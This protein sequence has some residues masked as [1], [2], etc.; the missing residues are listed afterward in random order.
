[1]ALAL[2][3]IVFDVVLALAVLLEKAST[4]WEA[5]FIPPVNPSVL[6]RSLTAISDPAISLT[7]RVLLRG[8]YS[9]SGG[10]GADVFRLRPLFNAFHAMVIVHKFTYG[11][12][13]SSEDAHPGN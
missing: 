5:L 3:C 9:E 12:W 2:F 13:H 8:S 1:M 11:H 7:F 10:Y 4:D 6:A